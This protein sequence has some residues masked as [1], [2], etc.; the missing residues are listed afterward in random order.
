MQHVI[1]ASV[2]AVMTMSGVA[3]Q[4]DWHVGIVAEAVMPSGS[5]YGIRF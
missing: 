1:V 5:T 3:D 4:Q 2:V